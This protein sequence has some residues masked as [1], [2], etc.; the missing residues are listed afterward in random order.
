MGLFCDPSSVPFGRLT[1]RHL[2]ARNNMREKKRGRRRTARTPFI[3]TMPM[4]ESV[5]WCCGMGGG[6]GGGRLSCSESEPATAP[7]RC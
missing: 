6:D 2:I 1:G 7:E 3:H 4:D 5:R